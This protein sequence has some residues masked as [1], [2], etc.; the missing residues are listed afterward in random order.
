MVDLNFNIANQQLR[1]NLAALPDGCCT[2]VL[3]LPN[4][5]HR[6]MLTAVDNVRDRAIL[7]FFRDTGCRATEA[8]SLTWGDEEK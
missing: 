1:I 8:L 5:N 2:V 3:N 6:A 7:L 4:G